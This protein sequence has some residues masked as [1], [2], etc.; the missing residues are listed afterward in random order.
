MVTSKVEE[1]EQDHGRQAASPVPSTGF[2]IP[3]VSERHFAGHRQSRQGQSLYSGSIKYTG[4]A[5]AGLFYWGGRCV[6]G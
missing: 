3:R 1:R 5:D 2:Y 6:E 4:S